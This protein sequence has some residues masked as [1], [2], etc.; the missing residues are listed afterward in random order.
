M[1]LKIIAMRYRTLYI[2]DVCEIEVQDDKFEFYHKNTH[3]ISVDTSDG[4]RF[5]TYDSTAHLPGVKYVKT[6]TKEKI[7]RFVEKHKKLRV[8]LL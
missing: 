7:E 4:L 5:V 1:V 8:K 2:N 3:W 6:V